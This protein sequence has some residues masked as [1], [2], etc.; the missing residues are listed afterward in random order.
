[1]GDTRPP[2]ILGIT[3]SPSVVDTSAAAASIIASFNVSDDLSGV[4]YCYVYIMAPASSPNRAVSCYTTSYGFGLVLFGVM[5]CTM[6]LPRYSSMGN[7]TLSEVMCYDNKFD[8]DGIVG[9]P[10]KC[11][12]SGQ[13]TITFRPFGI[14]LVTICRN[15]V[16]R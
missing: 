9:P 5:T 16:H 15:P 14:L 1:V 13:D 7:W 8:V 3:L 2:T 10:E 12:P 6:Q 11:P 4:Q